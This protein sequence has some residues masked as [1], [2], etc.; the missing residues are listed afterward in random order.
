MT[1]VGIAVAV[2]NG[3]KYLRETLAS[4]DSQKYGKIEVVIGND[5][6]TDSSQLIISE[7]IITS[8]QKVK[9]ISNPSNLGPI[10]NLD[11]I[12]RSFSD[13]CEI[14]LIL[15]QDD[16]ISRNHV[17]NIVK[18]FKEKNSLIN[19]RALYLDELGNPNGNDVAPIF[20]SKF[21][22]INM[23][24][25]LSANYIVAPGC[26]IRRSSY[27]NFSENERADLTG[28]WALFAHLL[29]GGRIKTSVR[30]TIGYRR[31]KT[32]LS[33]DHGFDASHRESWN[34]RIEFIS[35]EKFYYFFSKLSRIEKRIFCR[36]MTKQIHALIQC[37]HSKEFLNRLAKLHNTNGRYLQNYDP[38]MRC[39]LERDSESSLA[40]KLIRN[41]NSG[42]TIQSKSNRLASLLR[43][44][45]ATLA[46]YRRMILNLIKY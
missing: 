14:I 28:D 17:Y 2:Y 11:K 35:S 42:S 24:L 39:E 44:G 19:Y 10:G 21:Q 23:A 22:S 40:P 38:K 6:S 34:W 3:E 12:I 15:P 31:H 16:I 37:H 1:T 43:I 36:L 4:I 29:L 41:E 8:N 20:F 18:S 5:C 45:Y 9:L 32:N 13:K 33:R 27:L 26:A 25:M 7:Y 30:N 46:V